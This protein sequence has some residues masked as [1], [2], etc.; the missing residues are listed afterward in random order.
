MLLGPKRSLRGRPRTQALLLTSPLAPTLFLTLQPCSP[1]FPPS[2]RRQNCDPQSRAGRAAARI[3]GAAQGSVS[4]SADL[5]G[6]TLNYIASSGDFGPSNPT[7]RNIRFGIREHG[8]G[9]IANGINYDGLFR[10]SCATF[11]VFTDYLRGS[12]RVALRCPRAHG[13]RRICFVFAVFGTDSPCERRCTY[14]RMTAW[15]WARM[16]PR[17]NPLRPSPACAS[18][19]TWMVRRFFLSAA[20]AATPLASH[21][22]FS[23]VRPADPE[24]TAGAFVA[25]FTRTDGPTML[26]LT[27]QALPNLSQIPVEVRRN[28]VL[29]GAYIAIPETAPL[30]T[31]L[32]SCGSELQHA[33]AAAAK[34]R[35]WHACRVH[36]LPAPLR[37]A[38]C[39]VSR[40]FSLEAA[41]S[42]WPSRLVYRAPGPSTLVST[43]PSSES[44]ASVI[45]AVIVAAFS[46]AFDQVCQRPVMLS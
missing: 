15:V 25:A 42:E 12:M 26:S 14:S 10:C 44:T 1:R 24:E 19:P 9:G 40:N 37:Q 7:G 4:G 16:A 32:L 28:G 3:G 35:P 22:P 43:V 5:H 46:N 31:I 6:S 18:C 17:I 34:L 38:T 39:R 2:C 27:R 36:A 30:D 45:Y 13:T 23:V 33:V 11:L 41:A 20:Y 21:P 8:V 29:S